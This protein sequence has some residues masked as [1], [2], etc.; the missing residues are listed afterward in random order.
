MSEKLYAA[1]QKNSRTASN[2]NRNPIRRVMLKGQVR[3]HGHICTTYL[4]FL[5]THQATKGM[6]SLG[7][8]RPQPSVFPIEGSLGV[9][10]RGGKLIQTE[11]DE[12]A[13]NYNGVT[14]SSGLPRLKKWAKAHIGHC[15]QPRISDWSMGITASTTDGINKC[16]LL[17]TG[18]ASSTPQGISLQESHFL[19]LA[20]HRYC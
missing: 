7:G 14:Y 5:L 4:T 11:I 13:M 16:M 20:D 2:L 19:P 15:H 1:D 3:V 17:L 18:P 10:M 6:C 8:G 12:I 9:Q